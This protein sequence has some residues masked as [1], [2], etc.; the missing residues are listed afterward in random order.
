MTLRLCCLALVPIDL[1]ID[2]LRGPLTLTR[3]ACYLRTSS[4]QVLLGIFIPSL[5]RS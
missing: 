3:T 2:L 5:C 4:L 1:T